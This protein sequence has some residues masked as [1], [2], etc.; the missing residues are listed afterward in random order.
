MDGFLSA[1]AARSPGETAA[2]TYEVR[3]G[4]SICAAFFSPRSLVL[5]ILGVLPGL[6]PTNS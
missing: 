5:F 3:A 1:A 6:S 4:T 2:I